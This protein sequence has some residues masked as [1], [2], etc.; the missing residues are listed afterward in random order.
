MDVTNHNFLEALTLFKTH[1]TN[2][3]F[4][5]V[6]L[7]FTGLGESR[8]SQ[9]DT[10]AVRYRSAREDAER[11]PPIQF[12]LAIFKRVMDNAANEDA[13]TLVNGGNESRE[14]QGDAEV[15]KRRQRRGQSEGV[16]AASGKEGKVYG[17]GEMGRDLRGDSDVTRDHAEG[18]GWLY[19]RN[20]RST[21]AGGED[22]IFVGSHVFAS[23]NAKPRVETGEAASIRIGELDESGVVV[24]G[25]N[26][27]MDVDVERTNHEIDGLANR[28]ANDIPQKEESGL[29]ASVEKGTAASDGSGVTVSRNGVA[30]TDAEDSEENKPAAY[31]DNLRS[32]HTDGGTQ[33]IE[34]DKATNIGERDASVECVDVDNQGNRNSRWYVIPFNF[35]V[36]PRAVYYP[37]N[38]R[39]P[40]W[41]RVF[42]LQSSTVSFLLKHDFNFHKICHGGVGWIREEVEQELRQHVT[43]ILRKSRMETK[44]DASKADRKVIP[45]YREMINEWIKKLGDGTGIKMFSLPQT[46]IQRR[47]VYDMIRESYPRMLAGNLMTQEGQQLKLTRF[48]DEEE[49]TRKR[50]EALVKEIEEE[51]SK[52]VAFR[53]VIDAVRKAR[54][55]IVG[56]NA[57]LDLAKVHANFVGSMPEELGEFKRKFREHFPFVYDT[58]LMLSQLDKTLNLHMKGEKHHSISGTVGFVKEALGRMGRE[59]VEPVTFVPTGKIYNHGSHLDKGFMKDIEAGFVATANL[60]EGE[61]NYDFYEFGRYSG[62]NREYYEHEA[63]FDALETGRLFI[64]LLQLA[65]ADGKLSRYDTLSADLLGVR[66]KIFLSSCGGYRYIDLE[67]YSGDEHN[68]HFEN[69]NAIVVSGVIKEGEAG[70][71]GR[72][73]T[74]HYHRFRQTLTALT[75][76][77]AF[78]PIHSSL[79]PVG[80]ESMLA[81]LKRKDEHE[82]EVSGKRTKGMPEQQAQDLQLLIRQG[83]ELGVRVESYENA[84]LHVDPS[85]KRRKCV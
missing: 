50:E 82:S 76:G 6:D 8:P 31:G 35:N 44:K 65:Q 69:G 40:K 42:N 47:L 81:L 36:F 67:V 24:G 32:I 80:P 30:N 15:V 51:I 71:A 23:G 60:E 26:V 43:M 28:L 3:Q 20:A 27:Q 4:V 1:L 22:E 49:A 38:A 61:E 19:G 53:Y 79:M 72:L 56:H 63:G 68:D 12:G 85:T 2:A 10:P 5:A 66:N 13:H 57:L 39:Y 45:K 33:G 14:E 29:D 48:P 11:F 17:V 9:L 84:V 78:D 70:T 62:P 37:P 64:M 59:A 21:V 25:E 34:V 75:T 58:R 77:T 73:G 83:Q 18:K 7:E 74:S 46:G 55:P 41:D 52:H 16:L 54:I